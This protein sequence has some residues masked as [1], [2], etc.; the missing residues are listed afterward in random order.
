[1]PVSDTRPASKGRRW[2]VRGR[3]GPGA[4]A[5]RQ[6]LALRAFDDIDQGTVAPQPPCRF[7]RNITAV[8]KRRA[9]ALGHVAKRVV[10]DMHHHL[11][12]AVGRSLALPGHKPFEDMSQGI[13]APLTDAPRMCFRGNICGNRIRRAPLLEL[14]VGR[15]QRLEQ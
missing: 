15:F 12:S 10:G 11:V 13:R 5:H 1:M 14:R 3:H 2:P 6:R 7:H 9:A 4:A 8:L